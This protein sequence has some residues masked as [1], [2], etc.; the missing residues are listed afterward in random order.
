MP[1]ITMIYIL[2][3]TLLAAGWA[4]WLLPVGTCSECAHCRAEK[5]ARQRTN[6]VRT[7]RYYGI[8]LCRTAASIT[9]PRTATAPDRLAPGRGN[10]TR[11]AQGPAELGLRW[12]RNVAARARHAACNGHCANCARL[13]R[14]R[15]PGG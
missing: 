12:G 8:P 9:S 5:L 3:A 2:G 7:A 4:L 10:G 15:L 11:R 1:A 6:E 13:A 14:R